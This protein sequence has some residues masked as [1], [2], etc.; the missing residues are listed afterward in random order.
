MDIF[1]YAPDSAGAQAYRLLTM[2][3]LSKG[4]FQ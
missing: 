1:A 4:F 2:E 3:L